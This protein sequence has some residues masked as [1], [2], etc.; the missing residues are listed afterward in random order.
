MDLVKKARLPNLKVV[1][2]FLLE[3]FL[4]TC[5]NYEF[6]GNLSTNFVNLKL[7]KVNQFVKLF[8]LSK[9]SRAAQHAIF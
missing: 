4:E 1:M 3:I 7:K 6:L 8:L 2:S 9:K 5:K